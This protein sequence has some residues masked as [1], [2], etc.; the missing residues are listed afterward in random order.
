MRRWIVLVL[1]LVLCGVG[2]RVDAQTVSDLNAD[3][4]SS[5]NSSS[6]GA[7]QPTGNGDS[8]DWLFPVTKLNRLSPSWF[9]IGGE[10]RGRLEG[11]T[12]IGFGSTNDFYFLD[13][14]RLKLGIKPKDWLLFY[15]EVQDARIFFD[16]HIANANPYED[17]W[18]LWQAY[19]QLGS[20]ET[21]WVD[22]LAGRQVLR[23][24]DERV[25]GPSEWLNVGRTFNVARVDLH[26]PGYEVSVFASSVVPGDNSDLHNALP[27]NNMYGVYGSFRNIVPKAAFEPYV[28]WRVAPSNAE[29]SETLNRGHLN[30]VTVGLHWEGEL[31]AAFNYDTE[32][33]GQ[34]GSLGPSSIAAWAGYA[35]VGKTFRQVA[36]APHIYLEGNY[37]SGTRNPNG[38]E[39]NT[40]DQ[41]YPS[42]HD[43][44]G[45]ADQV[46]RRNLVHF[47]IGVEE[48]PTKK[49]KLKQQF[50]SYWLATSNDNFYAS[51]GAIA[52]AA[53]P[54]ASRHIGNEFDLVAEYEVNKG[55]SFG[56][57]YARMFAGQFLNQTTPGHDYSYPYA[58]FEYNFS[59]SG[60]HFPITP[61]KRN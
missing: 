22:A 48:E 31:P 5:T 2:Q 18:T 58:Y 7:P 20:S 32:F 28:L 61:N 55:L 34:T 35:S 39:W 38:H 4:G 59:K 57:G 10:Y 44:L 56:F 42:N 52:V 30:E 11:P 16:H 53:H 27:A 1:L 8:L 36:T 6:V 23:F 29:L 51:S 46:G 12:G 15:G 3:S 43:K 40:F 37:A 17:K 41:I 24:G 19:S 50:E 60:F 45:F 13:R 49:W 47:R 54:G 14:L 9:R 26:H 25:I 33:D 21:G